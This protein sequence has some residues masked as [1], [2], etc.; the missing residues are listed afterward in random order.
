MRIQRVPTRVSTILPKLQDVMERMEE[1]GRDSVDTLETLLD[2]IDDTLEQWIKVS[3]LESVPLVYR[4]HQTMEV[5]NSLQF[6]IDRYTQSLDRQYNQLNR[7]KATLDLVARKR[8]QWSKSYW[9]LLLSYEYKLG[10][11]S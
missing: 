7:M 4:P 10:T 2:Q 1:T 5:T 6:I 11:L 3:N 9:Y 8:Q